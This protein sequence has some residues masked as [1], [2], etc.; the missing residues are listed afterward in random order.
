MLDNLKENGYL[1]ITKLR[2]EKGHFFFNYI[3]FESNRPIKKQIIEL[4][5]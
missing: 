2:D 5:K 1:E 4:L 3:F